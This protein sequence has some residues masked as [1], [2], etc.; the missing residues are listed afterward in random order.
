[1]DAV[2]EIAEL[3][4][5]AIALK[6]HKKDYEDM[7]A[8]AAKSKL[9]EEAFCLLAIHLACGEASL[10]NALTAFYGDSLKSNSP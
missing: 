2:G 9:D 3:K 4:H 5:V 10:L 7:R 6:M 1:M 8:A